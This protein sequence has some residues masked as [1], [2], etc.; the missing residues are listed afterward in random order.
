MVHVGVSGNPRRITFDCSRVRIRLWVAVRYFYLALSLSFD[1]LFAIGYLPML[2]HLGL[3]SISLSSVFE[4]NL[5]QKSRHPEIGPRFLS[6]KSFAQPT[7]ADG[8]QCAR[9]EEIIIDIL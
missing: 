5:V 7:R 2:C 3:I 4:P 9:S 1:L 6:F 8:S